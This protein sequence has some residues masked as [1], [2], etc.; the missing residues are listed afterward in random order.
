MKVAIIPARGGSK[1][2]PR[3][4]I[5]LFAGKPIIAHSIHT[6]IE[7]G[8]FDRIIVS[9]DDDEISHVAREY[10]A[11]TPFVR[12]EHISTDLSGTLP[13]IQHAISWLLSDH[14]H[15]EHVC[16]LYPTAPFVTREILRSSLQSLIE[17]GRKYALPVTSFDFPVQRALRI[18]PDGGIDAVNPE[19]R[20]TRSQ[21]LEPLV[22]DA[23]QFCWGTREAWSSGEIVY[24]PATIPIYIPHYLVQDI[25]TL[26]DWRR[27]EW[28]F[29]AWK[30]TLNLPSA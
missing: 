15:P 28:L 19:F 14:C 11:E 1:R 7:A 23:G 25:D 9:T 3:K 18:M 4:N 13:V 20:F 2:I 21:D 27:A 24:S 5:R 16:C 12:P 8:I 26:D 17:S 29:Q 10:G 22:H 30:A 6:A